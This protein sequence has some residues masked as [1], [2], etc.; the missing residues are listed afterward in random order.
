MDNLKGSIHLRGYAEQDP[1]VAFKREGSRMFDDMLAGIRERVT[2]MIFKVRL[3]STAEME[4]VYQISNQVHEQLQGYDHLTQ[5]MAAQQEAAAQQVIKPIINDMQKVG[6]NAP[7][8]C[9]SGKKYKKCCGQ[10]A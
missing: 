3:A 2:D 9:G 8:P 4:S 1:K 10:D 6:R 5:D 7:C